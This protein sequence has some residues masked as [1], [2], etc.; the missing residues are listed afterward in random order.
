MPDKNQRDL[1]R[2]RL[3]I[4][5]IMPKQGTERRV[6]AGGTPPHPFRIV[7]AQYRNRLS[8][9][10]AAIEEAILPQLKLTKAAP[11]R[12]KIISKAA[13]KSHRPEKLFSNQSC[14]IIG[15]G[16]LGELFIKATPDGLARLTQIIEHNTTEQITKE[17][18]CIES[19]EAVTPTLR[20]RGLGAEDILRRSPRRRDR[21]I[22]RV[23]LFNFGADDDHPALVANFQ[24]VCA[25]RGIQLYQRG[26]SA[27]SF[28]YRGRVPNRG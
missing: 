13:A 12:V 11:V 1:R 21:F 18:S 28:T 22:T 14:P 4:K 17:L 25:E 10:V 26:Y 5:L 15:A 27:L 9:Q 20:R 3:P 8:N 2:D 7:D 23:R 6:P 24:T 16:R 19:I